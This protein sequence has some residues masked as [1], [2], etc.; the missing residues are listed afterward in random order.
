MVLAVCE[1]LMAVGIVAGTCV[2][3]RDHMVRK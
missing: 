3:G 1:D 2:R